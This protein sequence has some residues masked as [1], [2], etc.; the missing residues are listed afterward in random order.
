MILDDPVT[1]IARGELKKRMATVPYLDDSEIM[2]CLYQPNVGFLEP[3]GMGREFVYRAK[4]HGAQF[5][6]SS[7]V[8]EI[9]KNGGEIEGLTVN[10]DFKEVDG[11]VCAAGPWNIPM[12]RSIGIKLPAT[13]TLAPILMIEVPNPMKVVPP[14]FQNI[15]SGVYV[16]G[17]DNKTVYVGSYGDRGEYD[18]R[19]INDKIPGELREKMLKFATKFFPILKEAKVAKEWVGIR[20][21]VSDGVPIVGWT[22]VKGFSIAAFD[23]SGIQLSPA[24]GDIISKQILD[25]DQ[26]ELYE[27]VSITR[28]EGYNDTKWSLNN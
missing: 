14:L 22:E 23:S 4:K 26:T 27:N 13:H 1:Y 2:G 3:I 24:V 18:P 11:I 19:E 8:N 28:F 25:G 12:A 6:E 15:E 21:G 20:S 7:E 10:G 17:R 5:H 16:I 9:V